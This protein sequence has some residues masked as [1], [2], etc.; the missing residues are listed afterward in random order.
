MRYNPTILKET[1]TDQDNSSGKHLNVEVWV[2]FGFFTI[3]DG[4]YRLSRNVGK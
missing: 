2:P 4:S 1:I 3:E